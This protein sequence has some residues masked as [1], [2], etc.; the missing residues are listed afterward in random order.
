MR[1]KGG[2]KIKLPEDVSHIID[3]LSEQGHEAFAVGGCIRD[4]LLG[5]SPEDWDITTSATPMQVKAVFDRTVDTGIKHGTV[6]VLI[7]HTSEYNSAKYKLSS[8]EVTTYR[9]DGEYKDGRHPEKV[10]FSP[11]LTEDLKRRDFTVNAMAYPDEKGLVDEFSGLS[12]L[13]AGC[14]RCVGDPDERFT[15]D[16]LRILRAVRFMAQLGFE[17]EKNTAEAIK[18]HAENLALVSKERI[19]AELSKLLCSAHPER[20][21]KLWELSMAP[22]ICEGFRELDPEVF[23]RILDE[24]GKRASEE[25]E[26]PKKEPEGQSIFSEIPV[27]DRYLRYAILFSSLDEDRASQM[28][29]ELRM[30][31]ETIRKTR[32]LVRDLFRPIKPEPYEIKKAMQDMEPEL[33][34]KLLG[35]KELFYGT[36]RYMES[37]PE[38]DPKRLRREFE[39]ILKRDEPIYL[40]D[41]IVKGSDLVKAG[42]EPGVKLGELLSVMHEDVMRNP[43]HNSILYLFSKYLYEL[44]Q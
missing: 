41:L 5:R 25:A 12:D 2:V 23:S 19:Q 32:I 42:I 1:G 22:Y 18:G 24:A 44:K 8:Y 21:S 31:N 14:I 20:I 3:K 43:E 26:D 34:E 9:V 4:S 16:A 7:K 39:K 30:D 17:I 6:T 29:K 13:E 15:E 33:F 38:E 35:L 40:K 36:D 28:L 27:E 11:S 37:C 10:S